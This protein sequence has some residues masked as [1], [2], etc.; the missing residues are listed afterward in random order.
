MVIMKLNDIK[1]LCYENEY[2][3][4][5]YHMLWLDKNDVECEEEYDTLEELIDGYNDAYIDGGWDF[6]WIDKEGH[7]FYPWGKQ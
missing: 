4:G 5:K 3:D 2:N 7:E 1:V 6:T